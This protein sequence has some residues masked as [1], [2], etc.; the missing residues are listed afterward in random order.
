[1]DITVRRIAEHTG[2]STATIS[3]ILN[4]K[5]AHKPETI[6]RVKRVV[7]TLSSRGVVG[8]DRECVGIVLLAYPRFLCEEYTS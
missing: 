6:A 1:M 5:G 7:G 2:L 4:G 3:R 8:M